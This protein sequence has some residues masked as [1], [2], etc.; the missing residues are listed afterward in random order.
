[1]GGN[2]RMA[3]FLMNTMMAAGGCPWT[4]IPLPERKTYMAS[5]EKASVGQDIGPFADFLAHLVEKRLA[6]EPLPDV[7]K[8]TNAVE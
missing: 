8:S 3:R 2:G 5:L 1:M 7:P 4:V 6:G